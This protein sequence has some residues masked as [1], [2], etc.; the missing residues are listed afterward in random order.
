M[1]YIYCTIT[2]EELLSCTL[3]AKVATTIFKSVLRPEAIPVAVEIFTICSGFKSEIIHH[4][5]KLFYW[6]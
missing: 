2:L 4:F 3:P 1:N 6:G 5:F